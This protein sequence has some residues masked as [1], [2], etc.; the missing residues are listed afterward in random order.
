MLDCSD[1]AERIL[2]ERVYA[3]NGDDGPILT[4]DF[5]KN[6]LIEAMQASAEL[7][8]RAYEAERDKRVEA[9]AERDSLRALVRE[10]GSIHPG[11]DWCERRDALLKKGAD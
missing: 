3:F 5:L 9:E 1:M 7:A 6:L 2:H 4:R 11:D 8:D 10:I